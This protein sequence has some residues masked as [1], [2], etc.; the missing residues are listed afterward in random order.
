MSVDA[1]S[2]P[3]HISADEAVRRVA[4][5]SVLVDVREQ[6]EWDRG[7]APEALF[8]PMSQLA[9][10][11]DGLPDSEPLLIICHS[12]ARSLRVATALHDAGYDVINVDGGMEAWTSAGGVVVSEN[13]ESPLA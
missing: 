12:G 3:A 11:I 5:G 9:D 7:H 13:D 1:A 6:N 2:G 8:L 10:G 4:A